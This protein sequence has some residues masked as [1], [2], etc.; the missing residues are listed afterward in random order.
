MQPIFESVLF[1]FYLPYRYPERLEEVED[2]TQK[3]VPIFRFT[4]KFQLPAVVQNMIP[5]QIHIAAIAPER[6]ATAVCI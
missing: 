1:V 5:Y 6:I 4:K 2:N 3:A